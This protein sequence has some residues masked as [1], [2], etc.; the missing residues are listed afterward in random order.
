MRQY[1][2]QAGQPT[3][4]VLRPGRDA[5]G[6][7]LRFI[8]GGKPTLP[9][10]TLKCFDKLTGEL[11]WN[12]FEIRPVVDEV[13]DVWTARS[14]LV[15]EKYHLVEVGNDPESLMA[16]D[17]ISS[18]QTY[19]FRNLTKLIVRHIDGLTGVLVKEYPVSLV[20]SGYTKGPVLWPA[21]REGYAAN[22]GELI[23]NKRIITTMS[24]LL[25][26]AVRVLSDSS[27]QYI[28]GPVGHVSV[29]SI[30][31]DC[32]TQGESLPNV[33]PVVL[34]P[35]LTSEEIRETIML[36]LADAVVDVSVT[37]GAIAKAMV[38]IDIEF[39]HGD[40]C[41]NSVQITKTGSRP[42]AQHEHHEILRY[43]KAVGVYDFENPDFSTWGPKGYPEFDPNGGPY[44]WGGAKWKHGANNRTQWCDNGSVTS[45]SVD[46]RFG[47]KN[48]LD[49]RLCNFD[50]STEL[51]TE[52]WQE[53]EFG[54]VGEID[55]DWTLGDTA[56]SNL[57]WEED[58]QMVAFATSGGWSRAYHTAQSIQDHHLWYRPVQSMFQVSDD[59]EA[60]HT[61]YA[62]D[63]PTG[64]KLTSDEQ[65]GI[66]TH[67]ETNRQ[68]SE[69][70]YNYIANLWRSLATIIYKC[71]GI[72]QNTSR[73]LDGV[74]PNSSGLVGYQHDQFPVQGL[75]TGGREPVGF[76]GQAVYFCGGPGGE[77][78]ATDQGEIKVAAR[79]S[80]GLPA[81]DPERY[82]HTNHINRQIGDSVTLYVHTAIFNF[83]TDRNF[84]VESCEWRMNFTA[85]NI[86]ITS[87]WFE[88]GATEDEINASLLNSFGSELTGYNGSNGLY[89]HQTV[90]FIDTTMDGYN[91][92]LDLGILDPNNEN[93]DPHFERP[94]YEPRGNHMLWQHGGRVEVRINRGYVSGIVT[95]PELWSG[96]NGEPWSYNLPYEWAPLE[97]VDEDDHSLGFETPTQPPANRVMMDIELRNVIPCAAKEIGSMDWT[98]QNISWSRNWSGSETGATWGAVHASR[99]L[100]AGRE[101][102]GEKAIP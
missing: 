59:G 78:W 83:S 80:M 87:E 84:N 100:V 66:L 91:R 6:R 35:Y 43:T 16:R 102:P 38:T 73:I 1:R 20:K 88:H 52:N 98:G 39:A 3:G 9:G 50:I 12:R 24:P 18:Q 32:G 89:E 40:Y 26:V 41:L 15:A 19:D 23:N 86:T 27:M 77:Q 14:E 74:P 48:T 75:T 47:T 57:Y 71:H 53:A 65:T 31:F 60:K 101:V 95:R 28:I 51:W 62:G 42:P 44:G 7:E 13:G 37:G 81:S 8:P 67:F 63:Q 55:T 69:N 97:Y 10:V 33:D 93:Y 54:H 99:M 34:D 90:R 17:E 4:A 25:P 29:E 56:V 22:A 30:R 68:L 21:Q 46:E 2:Y 36:Q 94:Y 49:Y 5:H 11:L 72:P 82:K 70:G 45:L 76:D 92:L 61:Y 85:R 79:T 58:W 64:D 96:P